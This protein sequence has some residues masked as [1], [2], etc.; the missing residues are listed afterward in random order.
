MFRF[1]A[2][3]RVKVDGFVCKLDRRP[4]KRCRSPKRYRHIGLGRHV[5]RVRAIG[6][7]GLKG[8]AAT[9][10]FV[11]HRIWPPPPR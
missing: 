2:R 3:H 6:W 8:P 4:L 9:S 10:R 7:T 5:F 11:V 1:F